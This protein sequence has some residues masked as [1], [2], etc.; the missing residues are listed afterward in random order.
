MSA[1]RLAPRL[2][3]Q[4]L[5]RILVDGTRLSGIIVEVEAY[6]GAKDRAAHTFN[7]RRTER[8][9]A[10]Y[11]PPGTAYVYFTYGM[12]YCVNIVCGRRRVGSDAPGEAV[13]IRAIEPVEGLEVM[14]NHRKTRHDGRSARRAGVEIPDSHLCSGPAKLC[15]AMEIT[16]GQNGADLVE[17]E[18][19]FI[20][21]GRTPG[22]G[23]I[24]RSPRIGV[25]YAREWAAAPLRWFAAS[26]EHVCR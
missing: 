17:G 1:D 26:S 15:R 25:D 18:A 2:L 24:R 13:L 8:N 10:M 6:L 14:R 12:H 19:L 3:G 11:G 4:R 21:K 20:E 7:G 22:R 9:E 23:D 16:R 5:V